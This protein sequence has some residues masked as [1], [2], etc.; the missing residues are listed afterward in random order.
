MEHKDSPTAHTHRERERERSILHHTEERDTCEG[1]VLAWV[2]T[3]TGGKLSSVVDKELRDGLRGQLAHHIRGHSYEKSPR[4]HHA[5]EGV[6]GAGADRRG[7]CTPEAK[8]T[9]DLDFDIVDES[10]FRKGCAGLHHLR[11]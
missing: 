9:S 1:S 3:S 10:L 4:Q 5:R 7:D 8:P 6:K 2:V 11:Q